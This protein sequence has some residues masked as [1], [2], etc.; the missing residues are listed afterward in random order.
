MYH[1]LGKE[2]NEEDA[3]RIFNDG[4]ASGFKLTSSIEGDLWWA[5][6]KDMLTEIK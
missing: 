4:S 1:L 6:H 5:Y 3:K 2:I